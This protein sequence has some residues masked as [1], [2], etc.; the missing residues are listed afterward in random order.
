ML[1]TGWLIF[2]IIIVIFAGFGKCYELYHLN[3]ISKKKKWG[4]RK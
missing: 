4:K 2:V 1:S 3:E